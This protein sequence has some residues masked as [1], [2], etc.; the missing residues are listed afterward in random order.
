MPSESPPEL[1]SEPIIEGAESD[2]PPSAFG[3]LAH[4]P[5]K[6]TSD[7]F[8]LDYSG[9][10]VSKQSSH[11]SLKDKDKVS[12]RRHRSLGAGFPII[13]GSVVPAREKT[14]ERRRDTL[15]VNVRHTRQ[16]SASSSS[17]SHGESH[18]SRRL[19][20]SDYSH[21]PPS[22]GSSSIQQFLRHASTGST[23]GSPLHMSPQQPSQQPSAQVQAAL[24]QSQLQQLHAGDHQSN[25]VAHSLLRGTQEGW[26]DLDDQATVEA[27]R[28]L[29]GI[30]GKGRARSS[31]SGRLSSSSRPGTQI[32]RAH[33]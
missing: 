5:R 27:L 14:K 16:I 6:R 7:E 12:S 8:E 2:H 24:S 9:D 30:P 11:S 25:K 33:V 10:L 17:S 13:G 32:G 31:V 22:P 29:D 20:A 21:L 3:A 15:T 18:H 4:R 23:T 1:S 28:K 26:S 19:H